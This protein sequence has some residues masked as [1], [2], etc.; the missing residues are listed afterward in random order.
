M[1]RWRDLPPVVLP[2]AVPDLPLIV[3]CRSPRLLAMPEFRAIAAMARKVVID[4]A[5]MPDGH[6]ALQPSLA[7]LARGGVLLGDLSWT[8]LTRWREMLSQVFEN[9]RYLAQLAM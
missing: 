4:S 2:L 3:W 9:R 7:H 1:P 8:R 6:A 5:G